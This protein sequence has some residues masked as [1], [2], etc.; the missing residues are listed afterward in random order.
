VPLT[1]KT[2][3]SLLPVCRT[4]REEV[5]DYAFA[6]A[7]KITVN[8][9]LQQCN[10]TVLFKCYKHLDH[11]LEALASLWDGIEGLNV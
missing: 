3:A 4:I 5:V 7:A 6:K 2:I 1:S 11:E 9:M 10:S 8:R